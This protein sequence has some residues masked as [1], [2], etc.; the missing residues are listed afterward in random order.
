[1]AIA[2]PWLEERLRRLGTDERVATALAGILVEPLSAEINA[3]MTDA[4]L[5]KQVRKYADRLFRDQP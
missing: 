4:K 3:R 2:K 5:R 1:M